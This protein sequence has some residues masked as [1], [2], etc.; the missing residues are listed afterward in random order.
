M[1]AL[2]ALVL[3]EELDAVWPRIVHLIERGLKR[4]H[5][6]DVE[7]VRASLV[8]R[9]RQLWLTAPDADCALVTQIDAYPRS[10]VLHIFLIAGRLPAEWLAMLA[11]I[12]NWARQQGCDAA[13]LRGR[14]G[15]LRKMR[16]YRALALMR[17]EL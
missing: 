17:K 15:W 3:P 4:G 5:G 11:G 12:E 16:G 2:A 6:F 10:T 1:S 8:E 14:K 7:D 13:E 9:K